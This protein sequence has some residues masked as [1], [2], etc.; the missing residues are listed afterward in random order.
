MLNWPTFFVHIFFCIYFREIWILCIFEVYLFSR[1]P[2]KRKLTKIWEIW[3]NIYTQKLLR[4]RYIQEQQPN[5]YQYYQKWVVNGTERGVVQ[6]WF[7]NEKMNGGESLPLLARRDDVSAIFLKYSSKG[8]LSSSYVG[9][10]NILSEI[11]YDD[12]RHY[13]LQSE[14]RR[15]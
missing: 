6:D 11:C 2:F 15:I 3:G 4:L 13:Q 5:Q 14:H 1:M 10:W 12:I 7:P 8:R 9:I